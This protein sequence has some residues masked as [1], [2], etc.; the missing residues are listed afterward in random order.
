VRTNAI[1]AGI[2]AHLQNAEQEE[3]CAR[4]SSDEMKIFHFTEFVPA[5]L[6]AQAMT[7]MLAT[8]TKHV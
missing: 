8:E 7:R 1:K 6:T 2:A 5:I 4:I 3:T